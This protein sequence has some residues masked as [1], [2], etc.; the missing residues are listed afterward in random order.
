MDAQ[1]A[2]SLLVV[3]GAAFLLGRSQWKS[4]GFEKRKI[5]ASG[6]QGC[7]SGGNCSKKKAF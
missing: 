4:L 1:T 5:G 3:A 2:L 6:C 7:P